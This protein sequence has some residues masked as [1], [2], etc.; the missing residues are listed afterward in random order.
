MKTAPV[1]ENSITLD[2]I[3]ITPRISTDRTTINATGQQTIVNFQTLETNLQELDSTATFQQEFNYGFLEHNDYFTLE[4]N[5]TFYDTTNFLH[6]AGIE[7]ST[8]INYHSGQLPQALLLN[9]EADVLHTKTYQVN[10]QFTSIPV[11]T[12]I[13]A[14]PFYFVN[15][16]DIVGTT[17]EYPTV[18]LAP[19]YVD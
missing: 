17:I 15:G 3:Y 12:E 6:S 10:I 2:S 9:I 16:E 13:I 18:V 5:Y 14:S 8:T 7:L 1:V 11:T 19:A 4:L